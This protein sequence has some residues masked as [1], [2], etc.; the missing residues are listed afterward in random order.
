MAL[1]TIAS[2]QATATQTTIKNMKQMLDYLAWH[3]NATIRF[4]ALEIVLNIHSD[5]SYLSVERRQEQGS[6]TFLPWRCPNQ[7]KAHLPERCHLYPQ[8][9]TKNGSGISGR[10]RCRCA[11]YEHKGRKNYTTYLGRNGSPAIGHSHPRRQH[12]RHGHCERYNQEAMLSVILNAI[13]LCM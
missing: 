9:H 1:S 11:V 6:R 10:S 3:P 7:W 5:A 13:F 8:H 4:V 2:E 12:H